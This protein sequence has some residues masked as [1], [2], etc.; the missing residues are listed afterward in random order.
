MTSSQFIH[1]YV[2]A[3]MICF[4][5][6]EIII[7]FDYLINSIDTDMKLNGIFN[8]FATDSLLY[9][10]KNCNIVIFCNSIRHKKLVTE[11]TL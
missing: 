3:T 9:C 4:V 7:I 11:R 5:N 2:N 10:S 6:G 1:M 8:S